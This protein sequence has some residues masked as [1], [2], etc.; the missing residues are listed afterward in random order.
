S[1]K[2][3]EDRTSNAAAKFEQLSQKLETRMELENSKRE[4][5]RKVNELGRRM[6]SLT[7]EWEKTKDKKAII[8]KFVGL[9]TAEK[10]KKEANNTPEKVEKRRQALIEKLKKEIQIGSQVRMLKGKQ[11][12]T[13]EDIKKNTVIVNFGNMLAKVAIENL[14][15]ADSPEQ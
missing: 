1:L 11:V 4:E 6:L 15:L 10:K 5:T 2:N 7:E 12:G 13:V 14:E 8:K 3:K 9:M